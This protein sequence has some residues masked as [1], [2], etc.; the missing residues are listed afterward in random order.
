MTTELLQA[1]ISGP[2]EGV[3]ALEQAAAAGK[4]EQSLSEAPRTPRKKPHSLGH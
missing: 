1:P 2:H 3:H 4:E